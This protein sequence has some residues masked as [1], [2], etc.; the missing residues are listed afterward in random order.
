MIH[1]HNKDRNKVTKEELIDGQ[2]EIMELYKQMV[3]QF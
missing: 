1:G 2:A 3:Q